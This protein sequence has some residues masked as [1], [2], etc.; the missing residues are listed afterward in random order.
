VTKDVLNRAQ[1]GI[2][3][4]MFAH[5]GNHHAHSRPQQAMEPFMS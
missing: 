3:T 2:G 5:L 4:Q 1:Q